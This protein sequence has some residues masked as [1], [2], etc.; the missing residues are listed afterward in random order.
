[1]ASPKNRSLLSLHLVNQTEDRNQ[2][3]Y[4][5]D[6]ESAENVQVNGSVTISHCP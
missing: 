2:T 6:D 1:M 3:T 5:T 4:N